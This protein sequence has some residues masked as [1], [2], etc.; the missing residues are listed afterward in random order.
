LFAAGLI[1]RSL[2]LCRELSGFPLSG[3][4]HSRFGLIGSVA[5]TSEL[6]IKSG[7]SGVFA[8]GFFLQ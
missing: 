5:A 1:S 2:R 4:P 7:F 8:D 6:S 3:S